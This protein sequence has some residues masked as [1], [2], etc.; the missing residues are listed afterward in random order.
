[1][2]CHRKLLFRLS[3][4]INDEKILG[5]ITDWLHS[6][7][8]YVTFNHAQSSSATVTS[9]V[10][11]GSVLGPLL[12]IIYINDIT[13]VIRDTPVK[14]RLYADDCVLYTRVTNRQDQEVLNNVFSS[15]CGWSNAWQMSINYQKTVQ[16]TFTNKKQPLSF[17]YSCNGH[18]LNSVNTFKYLG[19]TFTQNLKWHLHIETICAR[20]LRKLG[21]LKWTLKCSTKDCKLTA[22][23]TITRE[24]LSGMGTLHCTWH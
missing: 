6:R 3:K 13:Q 5:W 23:Q 1:M 8:Q 15:F 11:Q 16:M 14:L 24:R 17:S 20:A 19:V 18:Y 9:G 21:Y 22:R 7:S 4:I 12:F 10:P 2:V